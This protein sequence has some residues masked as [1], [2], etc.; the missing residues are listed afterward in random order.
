MADQ[1]ATAVGT[2]PNDA[3]FE[4]DVQR[5][6]TFWSAEHSLV[7][8]DDALG[9]TTLASHVQWIRRYRSRQPGPAAATLKALCDLPAFV[10]YL[11]S[12]ADVVSKGCRAGETN[13]LLC[14]LKFVFS[15]FSND[16]VPREIALVRN[17]RNELTRSYETDLKSRCV[18]TMHRD[19]CTR[20]DMYSYRT[21][22]VFLSPL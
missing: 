8:V 6:I 2:D 12:R 20:R 1:D 22:N 13:S 5:L 19:T 11:D 9:K 10:R 16:N 4:R 3:E 14:V 17:L 15:P 18:K 21:T 7:R